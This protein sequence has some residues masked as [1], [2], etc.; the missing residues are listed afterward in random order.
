[1]V[2]EEKDEEWFEEC[3][4]FLEKGSKVLFVRVYVKPGEVKFSDIN[5]LLRMNGYKGKIIYNDECDTHMLL[6]N[7]YT[8]EMI[9]VLN[10]F[11]YFEERCLQKQI[12]SLEVF[13]QLHIRLIGRIR[14][15]ISVPG[16]KITY[17][18]PN[19]W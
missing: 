1:M 5:R 18:I 19:N 12:I 13:L 2:F 7:M 16:R 6:I 3:K 4:E 10:H 14:N 17:D 8:M 9:S 11:D 15:V